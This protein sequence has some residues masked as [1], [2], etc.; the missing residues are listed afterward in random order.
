MSLGNTIKSYPNKS[1]GYVIP[2]TKAFEKWLI[3]ENFHFFSLTFRQFFEIWIMSKHEEIHKTL[4]LGIK[5]KSCRNKTLDSCYSY[6]E[7]KE[8]VTKNKKKNNH[9]FTDNFEIFLEIL[10][11]TDTKNTDNRALKTSW[12]AT[13]TVPLNLL[14]LTQE[15][16]KIDL[17]SKELIFSLKFANFWRY[18]LCQKLR[19]IMHCMPE[20][21]YIQITRRIQMF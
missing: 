9:F 2:N 15:L 14:F 11:I 20:N 8:K 12:N 13:A 1:L 21:M 17:N 10:I 16:R 4:R 6:H 7:C 19:N 3:F 5:T 18:W